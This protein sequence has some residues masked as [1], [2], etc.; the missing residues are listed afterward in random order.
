MINFV[1]FSISQSLSPFNTGFYYGCLLALP[2]STTGLISLLRLFSQGLIAGSISF[3]G[4]IVGECLF[5]SCILFG[6]S[7]FLSF[8][9]S[10]FPTIF[11]I[12]NLIASKVFFQFAL[13]PLQNEISLQSQ[14]DIGK[15]FLINFFLSFNNIN[16]INNSNILFDN[17][18]LQF[19]SNSLF[20]IAI[21]LGHLIVSSVICLFAVDFFVTINSFISKI[22][23]RY[24]S[25]KSFTKWVGC[26]G[27]SFLLQAS[28][29][30]PWN[31]YF[32]YL[33]TNSSV[34]NFFKPFNENQQSS[35]FPKFE[36]EFQKRYK[37]ASKTKE[38]S[39]AVYLLTN[40]RENFQDPNQVSRLPILSQSSKTPFL[41][42]SLK[43]SSSQ[44]LTNYKTIL[45]SKIANTGAKNVERFNEI[46]TFHKIE[47][48]SKPIWRKSEVCNLFLYKDFYFFPEKNKNVAKTG[49]DD[50][51]GILLTNISDPKLMN[52][53]FSKNYFFQLK[54]LETNRRL[55]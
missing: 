9:V 29:Q 47:R 21:F 55:K 22:F 48:V 35:R 11:L 18:F 32:N 16:L 37:A 42:K 26:L 4:S 50:K 44:G 41:E 52:Q 25:I 45:T 40:Y 1:G 10:L 19:E 5:L 15:I 8:W 39:L 51:P 24:L 7:P 30:F 13:S 17:E 27:V 54:T 3:L 23:N 6:F 38:V 49:L 12:G 14:R 34:S 43:L 36:S 20:V 46:K 53:Y 31:G 2:L 33:L 28:F